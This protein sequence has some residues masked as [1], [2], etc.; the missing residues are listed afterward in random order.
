MFLKRQ[1]CA[2]FCI[3]FFLPSSL[4]FKDFLI[5]NTD[6]ETTGAWK[7]SW[8]GNSS[9]KEI[10]F[11]TRQSCVYYCWQA[12]P[13]IFQDSFLI[14][15]WGNQGLF[16]VLIW[17]ISECAKRP[18]NVLC[19]ST[20]SRDV[21]AVS[22]W[23]HLHGLEL[24][25]NKGYFTQLCVPAQDCFCWWAAGCF[26]MCFLKKFLFKVLQCYSFNLVR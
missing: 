23:C 17:K 5:L 6:T 26:P 21:L 16:L 13:C 22:N 15:L 18:V 9:E 24:G 14:G 11:L 12:L 20:N 4:S 2:Q 3:K 19:W 7:D 1:W 8:Q 10:K 25:G